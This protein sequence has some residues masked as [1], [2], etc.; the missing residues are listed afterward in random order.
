MKAGAIAGIVIAVLIVLAAVI[1]GVVFYM[2]KYK[3]LPTH[4]NN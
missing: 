2:K 4:P 3:K 1:G